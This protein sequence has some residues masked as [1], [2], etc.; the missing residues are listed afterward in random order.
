MLTLNTFPAGI[1]FF[2]VNSKDSR[3]TLLRSHCSGV[4][5]FD[6]EQVNTG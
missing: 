1:Y 5:I 3:M 6:I 2:K 4:S